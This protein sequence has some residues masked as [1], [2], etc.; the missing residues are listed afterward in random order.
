MGLQFE[1]ESLE[2]VDENLHSLY[3]EQEGGKYRLAVDGIDPAD[4]LKEALRKEREESKS[5]KQ[6]AKELEDARR[7]SEEDSLKEKEEFKTLY[8]REVE[9]KNRLKQ[10]YS[11]F[12]GKIQAKDRESAAVKISSELTRDTKRAALLQKEVMQ[13]AKYGDEGVYYEI[14]G[15]KV[16]AGKVAEHL[17]KEYPFLVDGNQASGGGAGGSGSGASGAK[18]VSREEFDKMSNGARMDFLKDG[19]KVA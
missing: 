11:D 3:Q 4:E 14:G 16:D 7:Q 1:V 13:F 9:E 19:G 15:I 17:T 6:R 12:E 2:G 10:Q 18:T 8:E 5:A